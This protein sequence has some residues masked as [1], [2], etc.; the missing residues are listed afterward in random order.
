MDERNKRGLKDLVKKGKLRIAAYLRGA[1]VSTAAIK[2][3]WSV[4]HHLNVF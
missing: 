2:E 3:I 1:N 4:G